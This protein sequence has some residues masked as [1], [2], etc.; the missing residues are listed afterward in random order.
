[1]RPKELLA[2]SSAADSGDL[3]DLLLDDADR[4]EIGAR[5]AVLGRHPE[6]QQA[7]VT[8]HLDQLLGEA[9]VLVDLRRDRCDVL[10]DHAAHLLA[11]QQVVVLE[12]IVVHRS[13]SQCALGQGNL[14]AS[15]PVEFDGAAQQE[16]L[17]VAG[18]RGALDLVGHDQVEAGVVARLV[19]RHAVMQRLDAHRLARRL[20]IEHAERRHDQARSA[21]GQA[22][23]VREVPPCMWP[24]PQMKS[25]LGTKAP[26]SWRVIMM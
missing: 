4:G 10:L 16:Q 5:A 25:T 19:E 23:S 1:M 8:E 15:T 12:M 13:R 7:H 21:F 17:L 24:A 14:R 22:A 20:E 18:S 2:A 9:V 3:G 11:Q 6:L 26:R